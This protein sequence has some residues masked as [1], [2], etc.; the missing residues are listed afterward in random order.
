MPNAATVCQCCSPWIGDWR[1]VANATTAVTSSSGSG[2]AG[3]NVGIFVKDSPTS[4]IAGA[5]PG[6]LRSR[7]LGRGS[8]ARERGAS[9]L[10]AGSA[11]HRQPADAEQP[12]RTVRRAARFVEEVESGVGRRFGRGGAIWVGLAAPSVPAFGD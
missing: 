4:T 12:V 5:P 7:R 11:G 8:D 6:I 1:L 9:A 10:E 2:I 3:S